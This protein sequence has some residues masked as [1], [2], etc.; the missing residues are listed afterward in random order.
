MTIQKKLLLLIAVSCLAILIVGGVGVI[1]LA[2]NNAAIADIG[3]NRMPSV[4]YLLVIKEAITDLSRNLYTFTAADRLPSLEK[5]KAEIEIAYTR[6][7][8]AI[9]RVENAIKQYQ[10]LPADAEEQAA[11]NKFHGTWNN[12]FELEKKVLTIHKS[13]IDNLSD[14][15]LRNAANEHQ[16]M[17]ETRRAIT[18][19]LGESLQAIIELNTREAKKSV[20]FAL[21]A[22]SFAQTA[23][24]SVFFAAVVSL[25]LF[26]LALGKSIVSP[27]NET[28]ST[29]EK[30]S[31]GDLT[32][33][34]QV[35]T[36]RKD[37]LARLQRATVTMVSE[38]SR[39]LRDL[40]AQ[41]ADLGN[42]SNGLN[43]IS[44]QV[45]KGSEEQSESTASMAAALEEMS[46]S[47]THVSDLSAEAQRISS[48]S[49]Q[50][51]QK[52]SEQIHA[53]VHDIGLIARSI[54]TAAQSAEALQKASDQVSNV[55]A[56][57]KEVADQT[58]LLALNA[59]IEAARAGEQ[60]RGF[61]VVADEV[62]KLAEKTGTS[63]QEIATMITSMQQ[64]AQA[65]AS[66][67]TLSVEQVKAGM[68]IAEKTGASIEAILGGATQVVAIVDDVSRALR[69]Q[70]VASQD[71]AGRVETIAQMIDGNNHS[72]ETVADTA[73]QLD[74]LA[75]RLRDDVGRFQIA[76]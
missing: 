10:A 63:A 15:S 48:E 68:A 26:G 21:N 65:M 1:G 38:L 37:E 29:M 23:A 28:V 11:W 13:T 19:E 46:T 24:I 61:A 76:H 72:M 42:A 58:N 53:M 59:A 52:G 27:L 6:K 31:A 9:K 3:H 39:M 62:R 54:E 56:V 12:W 18:R 51:A 43:A 57:I 50:A 35:D 20:D 4:N 34:I 36:S 69:E 40:Q 33:R 25:V 71:I 17:V 74:H 2:K 70:A 32:V 14:E 41:S 7:L 30:V 47:I 22:A 45:L 49:G 67:M 64:G 44:A 16:K 5:K 75:I 73:T 8:D 55:T 66:Q 60:G